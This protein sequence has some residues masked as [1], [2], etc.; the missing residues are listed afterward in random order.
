MAAEL[1]PATAALD[2]V[3]IGPQ[4]LSYRRLSVSLPPP[5]ELLGGCLPLLSTE[6]MVKTPREDAL[7]EEGELGPTGRRSGVGGECAPSGSVP[8]AGCCSSS[9]ASTAARRCARSSRPAPGRLCSFRLATWLRT[10]AGELECEE[11][12]PKTFSS[13]AS[14]VWQAIKSR[15]RVA[16]PRCSSLVASAALVSCSSLNRSSS[17][18]ACFTERATHCSSASASRRL[19][20]SALAILRSASAASL[21]LTWR[22]TCS[23]RY[24]WLPP[25]SDGCCSPTTGAPC[26]CSIESREA[27]HRPQVRPATVPLSPA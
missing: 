17:S 1:T 18:S 12:V 15:V 23:R 20:L 3:A 7:A 25:P 5:P 8:S 21:R 22:L 2:G 14:L 10:T 9:L 16:A 4:Q 24:S 19:S 26:H 6:V 11:S 27:A 13:S